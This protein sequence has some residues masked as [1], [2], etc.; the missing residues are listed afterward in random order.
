MWVC[1][2]QQMASD[3]YFKQR[4]DADVPE[5]LIFQLSWHLGSA[6]PLANKKQPLHLPQDGRQVF[7]YGCL[8][9]K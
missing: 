5:T 1:I 3:H 6:A 7:F 9:L 8:H 4:M 2:Q